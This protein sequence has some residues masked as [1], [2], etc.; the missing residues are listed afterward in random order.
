MALASIDTSTVEHYSQDP[1]PLSSLFNACH[2][3]LYNRDVFDLIIHIILIL[4]RLEVL[5][6][7]GQDLI[8]S[9]KLY[10]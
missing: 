7:L 5:L 4:P 10:N 2:A 9:Y 8:K 6:D 1:F 3:I